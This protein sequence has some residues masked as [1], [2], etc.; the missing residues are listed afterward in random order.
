MAISPKFLW[1]LGFL[2]QVG[3]HKSQ[4]LVVWCLGNL[5]HNNV[6]KLHVLFSIRSRE[7][8]VEALISS[9][10]VVC[11]SSLFVYVCGLIV[12]FRVWVFPIRNRVYP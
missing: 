8:E 1:Y 9:E 12:L 6:H 4:V 7:V 5:G 3:G 10:M 2:G 11:S